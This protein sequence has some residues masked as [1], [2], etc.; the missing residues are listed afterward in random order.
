[1]AL[2]ACDPSSG[3]TLGFSPNSLLSPK[4]A[5]EL[6]DEQ[7]T[8]QIDELVFADVLEYLD[9]DVPDGTY[10]GF[11]L[12]FLSFS[13]TEY[14][15]IY[16][17]PVAQ[18]ETMFLKYDK[19][20]SGYIDYDEFRSMW[21]QLAN[22]QEELKLRDIEIPKKASQWTLQQMLAKAIAEEEQVEERAMAEAK[23][24][25]DWQR[26]Q[27]RRRLL[28]HRAKIVAQEELASALDA[29]G[30]VYILGRGKYGQFGHDPTRT[31]ARGQDFW[32]KEYDEVRRLWDL[33]VDPSY[34]RPDIKRQKMNFQSEGQSQDG[35]EKGT[36]EGTEEGTEDEEPLVVPVQEKQK[37]NPRREKREA[38]NLRLRQLKQAQMVQRRPQR[39]EVGAEKFTRE[40]V[41]LGALNYQPEIKVPDVATAVKNPGEDNEQVQEEQP[42]EDLNQ[43]F[44]D[45]RE[46]VRSLRFRETKPMKNTVWLWGQRVIQGVLGENVAYALT[47]TGEIFT[48]GGRDEWWHKS[49]FDVDSDSESE[50]DA[51]KNPK[52]HTNKIVK[53]SESLLTARSKCQKSLSDPSSWMEEEEKDVEGLGTAETAVESDVQSQDDRYQKLKTLVQYYKQWEPPPSASTRMLFMEQILLPRIS[54]QTLQ[55]SMMLRGIIVDRI[56]KTELMDMTMNAFEIEIQAGNVIERNTEP[57]ELQQID[58]EDVG[59]VERETPRVNPRNNPHDFFQKEDHEIQTLDQELLKLEK[60]NPKAA[61]LKKIEIEKR[62]QA[63]R[64]HWTSY[65]DT[66]H[67]RREAKVLEK[68][69]RKKIERDEKESQY[70]HLQ[71]TKRVLQEDIF[72]E[73]AIHGTDP[74]PQI[75]MQGLTSR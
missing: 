30:Q 24:W 44:Y 63:F 67:T 9:L 72:P 62:V 50:E 21:L 15:Y 70:A 25:L 11:Y 47:D 61:K 35:P 58:E 3:N 43:L 5:F 73:L 19:D 7:R 39:R 27:D 51:Q 28:G 8:G 32:T 66:Y 46:Y 10:V 45:D 48:W 68:L 29:A 59:K 69:E 56:T 57:Q 65:S 12:L 4:D 74:Q 2:F 37:R 31:P 38:E 16:M 54:F 13:L 17:M 33:R 34:E 75:H 53:K 64:K 49:D 42:V 41:K 71:A 6:F 22:I 20:R 18:M 1:M 14:I 36:E 60:E 26:E 23:W 40:S 52:K 55:R